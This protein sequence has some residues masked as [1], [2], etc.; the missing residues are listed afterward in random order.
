MG[1]AGQRAEVERRFPLITHLW[2]NVD[3]FRRASP[4][5]HGFLWEISACMQH[6]VFSQDVSELGIGGE[7]S[8]PV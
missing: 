3:K 7:W 6:A 1:S 4:S 8:M 2:P 5:F